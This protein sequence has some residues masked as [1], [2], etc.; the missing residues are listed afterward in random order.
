MVIGIWNSRFLPEKCYLK[1]TLNHLTLFHMRDPLKRIVEWGWFTREVAETVTYDPWKYLCYRIATIRSKFD[2]GNS[3][4]TCSKRWWN[5]LLNREPPNT[6]TTQRFTSEAKDGQTW[7]DNSFTFQGFMFSVHVG[8][9][10]QGCPSMKFNHRNR[11][12]LF[13][14]VHTS[15]IL[16]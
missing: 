9:V 1:V 8:L 16:V 2:S 3:R 11:N 12:P 5:L 14:I 15:T 4:R 10:W 6:A 7:M 13:P